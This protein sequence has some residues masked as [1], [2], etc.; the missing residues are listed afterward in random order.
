MEPVDLILQ[1]KTETCEYKATST[2]WLTLEQHSPRFLREIKL[3]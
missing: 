3:K 1:K 2:T